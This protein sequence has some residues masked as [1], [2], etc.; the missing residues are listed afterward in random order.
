MS[1][2]MGRP[3]KGNPRNMKLN[4]RLTEQEHTDIQYCADKLNTSRTEAIMRGIELLKNKME[5]SN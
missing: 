3:P 4:L 2:R 5:T 1:P